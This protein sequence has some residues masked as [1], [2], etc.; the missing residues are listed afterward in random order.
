MPPGAADKL[1]ELLEELARWSQRMNLTAIRDTAAMVSGHVLDSLS[2]RPYLHGGRII[3]IGTGAGFP[4]LPLAIAEPSLHFEL[5]DSNARKIG[6][7]QHI[8]HRL[9]LSNVNA[10]RARAED[11]APGKRFDTVLAR[12]VSSTSSLAVLAAPLLQP[13]GILLAMKGRDPTQE[14]D[15]VPDD[16][17]HRVTAV[18]VPGLEDHARHVVR[19][20][21]KASA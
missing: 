20:T 3:D 14:L 13:G 6:F 7:V 9:G 21:L 4:G 10:V 1:A 17:T 16:W 18:S 2:V 8:A 12:A 19:L 5:L 11:Y 15:N